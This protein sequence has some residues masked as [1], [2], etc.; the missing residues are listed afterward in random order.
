M[1][2]DEAT[3]QDQADA[4]ARQE[5]TRLR[6]DE[7]VYTVTAVDHKDR[8]TLQVFMPDTIAT[9]EDEFV[10]LRESMYVSSVTYR[11]SI[12][13]GTQTELRLVPIGAIQ[14]SDADVAA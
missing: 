13:A 2:H 5:M 4:F 10:G 11:K 1:Q 14:F 6:Q 3:T 7:R 8:A 9:V 12:S